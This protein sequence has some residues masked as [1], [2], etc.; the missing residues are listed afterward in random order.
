M[1]FNVLP[2]TAVLWPLRRTSLTRP[3]NLRHGHGAGDADERSSRLVRVRR[4]AQRLRLALLVHLDVVDLP[5]R[6]L[7]RRRRGG[8]IGHARRRQLAAHWIAGPHVAGP[9]AAK[10]RVEED[11][12][13]LEVR[14]YVAAALEVC[15]RRAPRLRHGVAA[16]DVER[17]G[18]AREEPAADVV[19][20]PL[21][22]VHAA[23]HGVEV[24][25]ERVGR[26]VLHAAPA[27]VLPRRRLVA[28]CREQRTRLVCAGRRAVGRRVKAHEILLGQADAF[29]HAAALSVAGR[30]SAA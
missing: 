1:S 16:L 6:V 22:R 17:N 2:A 11:V 29:Y 20:R 28:V 4:P 27:A 30:I 12:V 3:A 8:D 15:A 24:G 13:L 19:C 25:P 10:G 18:G 21:G 9:V 23:I 14:R 26:V 7:K 5:V